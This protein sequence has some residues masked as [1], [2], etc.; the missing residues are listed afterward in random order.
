MRG[1]SGWPPHTVLAFHHP[2][3]E[4]NSDVSSGT[5]LLAMVAAIPSTGSEAPSA[6]NPWLVKVGPGTFNLGS[7]WLTLPAYTALEGAGEDITV[8]TASGNADSHATVTMGDRGRL[9]RLTVVST[10][11]ND[12]EVAVHIPAGASSIVIEHASVTASNQ[13][14]PGGS[15][16]GVMAAAYASFR[17]ENCHVVAEGAYIILGVSADS[18]SSV[19]RLD[20]VDVHVSGSNS[21]STGY[22][23]IGYATSLSITSSRFEVL[24]GSGSTGILA[25]GG[26]SLELRDSVVRT[27]GT[28]SKAVRTDGVNAIL[29]GDS[30]NAAG[31]GFATTGSGVWADI[32]NC[33]ITG[34]E[35]SLTNALGPTVTVGASKL[36]GATGGNSTTHCFGNYTDTAFLATTCP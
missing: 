35:N 26:G 25:T 22:G 36:V 31:V 14:N 13:S 19:I 34:V 18:S 8:I 10:G 27:N 23:L 7:G 4:T 20:S 3:A 32:S 30:L 6:S 1:A 24:D 11:G 33:S 21:S 28:G 9:S 12:Y 16:Y 17:L 5:E 29:A 15:A 2:A